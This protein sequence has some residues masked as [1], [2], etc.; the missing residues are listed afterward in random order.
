MNRAK[1]DMSPNQATWVRAVTIKLTIAMVTPH[2]QYWPRNAVPTMT[3][4]TAEAVK[5]ASKVRIVNRGSNMGDLFISSDS[6]TQGRLRKPP[7]RR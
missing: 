6:R 5:I 1:N 7:I 3:N 2:A 4:T